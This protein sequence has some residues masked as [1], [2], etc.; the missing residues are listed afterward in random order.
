MTY[1]FDYDRESGAFYIRV[2]EG[3]YSETIPL[4]SIGFGAGVDIDQE[5]NVLGFEF[6][7]FEEF[8]E[9]IENN[10]GSVMIPSS[11]KAPDQPPNRNVPFAREARG[12]PQQEALRA[13]RTM[14]ESAQ[15]FA[16]AV[17]ESYRTVTSRSVEAQEQSQM[18]TQR[19]LETVMSELEVAERA[20]SEQQEA[21]QKLSQESLT[22]YK[23]FMDSM[24]AYYQVNTERS[25]KSGSKEKGA[26]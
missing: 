23:A 2:R 11:L 5:G 22:A 19:F 8:A 10:D 9:F 12:F 20:Q 13:T 1:R 17:R 18:L 6:L 14:N 21:F 25:E 26:K 15:K 16:E 4:V 24:L 3:E 7:S